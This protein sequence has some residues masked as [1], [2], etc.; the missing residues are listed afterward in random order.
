MRKSITNVLESHIQL[1]QGQIDIVNINRDIFTGTEKRSR[2]SSEL[3]LENPLDRNHGIE[4]RKKRTIRDK[5]KKFLEDNPRSTRE[6]LEH[7]NST[8]RDD[9]TSE[10]VENILAKD[11]NFI[12]ISYGDSPDIQTLGVWAR[13]ARPG[14]QSFE[15]MVARLARAAMEMG[16]SAP[17]DDEMHKIADSEDGV[18]S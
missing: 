1:M 10:Y 4:P 3:T 11:K 8:F 6:I 2:D 15:D 14:D 17:N 5:V 18:Q 9:Y 7:I 12:K 16:G 13:A